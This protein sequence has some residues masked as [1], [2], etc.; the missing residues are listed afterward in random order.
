M[1]ILI[2]DDERTSVDALSLALGQSGYSVVTALNGKAALTI[3]AGQSPDLIISDI[4]M[5]EL[6]GF[7]FIEAVRR[8][9]RLA[10][11]PFLLM[12]GDKDP[13]LTAKAIQMGAIDFLPKPINLN[14]LFLKIQALFRF[15]DAQRSS[16]IL[17]SGS[18]VL[19][20]IEELI[21]SAEKEGVHG[22]LT[23]QSDHGVGSIE[24][25]RGV[26]ETIVCGELKDSEALETMLQWSSGSYYLARRPSELTESENKMPVSVHSTKE[27]N[28]M[29]SEDFSKPI[30]IAED[31][32]FVGDRKESRILQINPFLRVYNNKVNFLV[33]PGPTID[34]TTIS[35]KI[36]EVIGDVSKVNLYSL[37]HQDPD[38]ASNT[39]FLKSANPKAICLTSEDT[40]RLVSSF[41]INKER[42]ILTD[43][44]TNWQTN[45]PTGHTLQF[46]PTPYCHFRGAVMV[47]DIESRILFSGDLFGGLTG[48]D[49][50]GLWADES[51][52]DGMR[53]FHE[54]YMPANKAIQF[55]IDQIRKLDPA[56]VMIAPQHGSLIRGALI[57]EFLDRMY[58]LKV[59]VDLLGRTEDDQLLGQYLEVAKIVYKKAQ[60][61][62][63]NPDRIL[64]NFAGNAEIQEL[65]TI[66]D[67]DV[68]KIK[69]NASRALEL[70]LYALSDHQSSRV[71]NQIK[72]LML[73]ETMIRQLPPPTFA[74]EEAMD[75]GMESF[76]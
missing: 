9:P 40:W 6:D 34:Y 8:Q 2:V 71:S 33:D 24:F 66:N 57:R 5:P 30:A 42:L 48:T 4:M 21:A 41:G 16:G 45:L 43:K 44:L 50:Y 72:A 73:Q 14:L 26:C 54:L 67:K 31:I 58:S 7:G 38:V 23:I 70:F 46:I 12:S 69:K 60:A 61:M 17:R 74:I 76:T 64:A 18:L 65:M 63:S 15:V 10:S 56:P 39:F 19:G 35:G 32:Y 52:W 53:A 28:A 22:I 47:Y 11:I 29:K 3:L 1:T 68:V 20:K 75:L 59:G 51:H 49:N 27:G 55:A 13:S 25:N 62:V 36:G 37:N